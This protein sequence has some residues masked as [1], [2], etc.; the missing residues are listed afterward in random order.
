MLSDYLLSQ[1]S[2]YLPIGLVLLLLSLDKEGWV[3]IG[4][5]VLGGIAVILGLGYMSKAW[6]YLKE[7]EKAEIKRQ[8][9]SDRRLSE[10]FTQLINEIK[11]LRQDL[12][13]T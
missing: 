12:T 13:N 7:K 8:E 3:A 11:G 4:L 1:G 2:V 9:Y 10:M 5:W 6:R